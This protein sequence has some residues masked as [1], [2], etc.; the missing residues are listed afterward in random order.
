MSTRGKR[1]L[2][3]ALRVV[4][5]GAVVAGCVVFVRGLDWSELGKDL[6]R[7]RL[8]PL[9]LGAAL[10]FGMMW[11]KAVCWRIMLAPHARVGVLRIFRYTVLG[12]AAS[13]VIPARAGEILRVWLLKRRD[14]VPMR[15]SAAVA[16][17]E[18]LVDAISMLIVCAPIP[19]LLP[20]LPRWVAH[21]ILGLFLGG[22]GILIALRVIMRRAD[23]ARWLG[24]FVAGM[25]VLRQPR[26][27]ALSLL[28]CL[29]VW[30]TDIIMVWLVVYAV[31][32][33]IPLAGT[34]LI[35][36]TVN[37]AILIPSTP[38]YIGAMEI[39][40]IVALDLLG[41]PRTEG[42]AFGLLYHAMQVVPLVLVGLIDLK[43]V[44]ALLR[45]ARAEI[46][47]PAS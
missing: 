27:L 5:A 39:G 25:E 2:A 8:A 37:M 34:L 21:S 44:L 30:A 40:A 42:V 46:E 7:A 18:K 14:D 12:Y 22:V 10:S 26:G 43:P 31:G 4:A 38:A 29:G 6:A 28:A 35:L 13:T 15:I 24:R 19:L 17:A 32:I 1:I 20:G 33:Q 36:F 3:I 16:V 11:W 45:Q 9:V 41:V 23:P 47:P